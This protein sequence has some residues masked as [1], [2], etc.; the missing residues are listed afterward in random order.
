MRGD[1][2]PI[3]PRL[4]ERADPVGGPGD[5]HHP[6]G[7]GDGPDRLAAQRDHLGRVPQ[8]QRA[9]DVRGGD[10]ALRVADDGVGVHTQRTPQ[11]GQRH[12]HREQHRLHDVDAVQ[13]RRARHAPHARRSSDQ[14]TKSA[15]ASWQQRISSR[16]RGRAIQQVDRHARPLRALPG[17]HEH[18]F[19]GDFPWGA[20]PSGDHVRCRGARRDGREPGHQLLAG[21]PER[22]RRGGRRRPLVVTSEYPTSTGSVSGCASTNRRNRSA[23]AA[24]RGRRLSGQ[25]P[26]RDRRPVGRRFVRRPECGACSRMTCAFVPLTPNDDTAGAPWALGPVRPGACRRSRARSAPADQSTCGVGASTC[27]VAGST[28]CAHRHAPS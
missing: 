9:G 25:H 7:A 4:D 15:N 5:R 24:Q 14:S 22:P 8:R 28:P 27:S 18:R 26:R 16:E 12:H 10:L 6:A 2:Y 3:A 17:E 23:C 21:G 1:T 11:R 13:A 19:P 20:G